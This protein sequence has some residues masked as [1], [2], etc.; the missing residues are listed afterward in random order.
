MN[1]GRRRGTATR[2]IAA[3]IGKH[4]SEADFAPLLAADAIGH[5]IPISKPYRGRVKNS[6]GPV[7]DLLQRRGAFVEQ[8]R[9]LAADHSLATKQIEL[10]IVE[11]QI[12]KAVES[13]SGRR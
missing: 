9:A 13:L 10:N 4:G 6:T 1:C 5:W 12:K 11:E 2:E 3:A 7:K 8:Q